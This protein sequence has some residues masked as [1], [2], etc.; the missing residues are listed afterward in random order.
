MGNHYFP[1]PPP[2]L[3]MTIAL[4]TRKTHASTHCPIAPSSGTGQACCGTTSSSSEQ[5]TCVWVRLPQSA[6][7]S[8]SDLAARHLRSWVHCPSTTT[9][10]RLVPAYLTAGCAVRRTGR[11]DSSTVNSFVAFVQRD[12]PPLPRPCRLFEYDVQTLP[13]STMRPSCMHQKRGSCS[14][15]VHYSRLKVA[16][17]APKGPLTAAHGRAPS[18]CTVCAA[19]IHFAMVA[20]GIQPSHSVCVNAITSANVSNTGSISSLPS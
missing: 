4:A 3:P 11:K 20:S 8:E 9:D 15:M 6:H 17:T 12:A 13:G 2:P 19:L 18:R 7:R 5:R 10:G 14:R 16:T 1:L